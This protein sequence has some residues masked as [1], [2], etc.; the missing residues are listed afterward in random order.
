M[1][2]K[3]C[4][5]VRTDV[6]YK[7]DVEISNEL[8]LTAVKITDGPRLT[9][10]R[11]TPAGDEQ[12]SL[13]IEV[14]TVTDRQEYGASNNNSILFPLVEKTPC[15]NDADA[16]AL[17]LLR[18]EEDYV[19]L[20]QL[21]IHQLPEKTPKFSPVRRY[22]SPATLTEILSRKLILTNQDE[23]FPV[24]PHRPSARIIKQS[25][26]DCVWPLTKTWRLHLTKPL[27]EKTIRDYFGEKILLFIKFI[28]LLLSFF[29]TMLLLAIPCALTPLIYHTPRDDH[30]RNL[31]S[32]VFGIA[33]IIWLTFFINLWRYEQSIFGMKFGASVQDAG[34]R[35]LP[36][37]RFRGKYQR[38]I[39]TDKFNNLVTEKGHQ[40]MMFVI[41]WV[42]T[43][44]VF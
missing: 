9:V 11:E 7:T 34:V 40:K 38:S 8:D 12:K 31:T 39:E 4:I 17:D 3:A 21:E 30:I 36:R 44:V 33:T 16:L 42:V 25:I 6:D 27:P 32:W 15:S 43:S 35:G 1:R 26:A 10:I 18:E 14:R 24:A 20:D 41:S 23:E 29:L 5:L 22:Q 13:D 28:K 19:D 2:D 37:P